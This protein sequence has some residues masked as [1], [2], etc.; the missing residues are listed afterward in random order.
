MAAQW[1]SLIADTPRSS[2]SLLTTS[3]SIPLVTSAAQYPSGSPMCP[4]FIPL[5]KEEKTALSAVQGCWNCHGRPTDPGWV[6]HQ[7]STYPGNPAVGACPGKDYVA[8][9]T[10]A[11]TPTSS[12]RI[13]AGGALGHLVTDK[14]MWHSGDEYIPMDDGTSEE[15]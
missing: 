11:D 3:T 8:P 5:T 9:T 4:Q 1:D 15:E 10:A 13:V 12:S 2:L 6:P 14:S 7:C